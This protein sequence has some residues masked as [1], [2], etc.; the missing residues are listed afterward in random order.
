MRSHS[1]NKEELSLARTSRW[2]ELAGWLRRLDP[3]CCCWWFGWWHG[4][5]FSKC[6]TPFCWNS[7][8]F[9]FKKKINDNCKCFLSSGNP[10]VSFLQANFKHCTLT[11]E[12]GEEEEAVQQNERLWDQ[13]SSPVYI[14][15]IVGIPHTQTHRTIHKP[16]TR[17]TA[18]FMSGVVVLTTGLPKNKSVHCCQWLLSKRNYAEHELCVTYVSV[19]QLIRCILKKIG[20][21]PGLVTFSQTTCA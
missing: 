14:P 21:T 2:N 15:L 5:C 1:L 8:S 6:S 13:I 11:W 16:A 9:F 7:L 20:D 12:W 10:V 19:C 18:E 3:I 4:A 17:G